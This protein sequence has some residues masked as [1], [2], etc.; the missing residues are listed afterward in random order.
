MPELYRSPGMN[1]SI[2]AAL[3]YGYILRTIRNVAVTVPKSFSLMPV[4]AGIDSCIHKH[5]VQSDWPQAYN[6]TAVWLTDITAVRQVDNS[7]KVLLVT[8]VDYIT[9]SIRRD[10][11]LMHSVCSLLHTV[12]L[13]TGSASYC[14]TIF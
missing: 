11:A 9:R 5:G 1:N 14:Q 8:Y 13:S 4:R 10:D 2:T 3:T 6:C 12:A 7:S